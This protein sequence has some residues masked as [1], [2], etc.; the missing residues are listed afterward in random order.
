MRRGRD[1]VGWRAGAATTGIENHPREANEQIGVVVRQEAALEPYLTFSKDR[2]ADGLIP[3][4]GC[5][6]PTFHGSTADLAAVAAEMVN[7]P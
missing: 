5:S 6:Y 3:N 1:E 4:K 7:L 2:Q